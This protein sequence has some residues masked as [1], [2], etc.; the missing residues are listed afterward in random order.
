MYEIHRLNVGA[1]LGEEA[2]TD[3]ADAQRAVRRAFVRDRPDIVT[4]MVA[5]RTELLMRMLMPAIVP[6]NGLDVCIP[7]RRCE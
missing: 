6:H 4:F 7:L 2:V 3:V 5:L 1:A